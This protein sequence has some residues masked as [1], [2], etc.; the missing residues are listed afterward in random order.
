MTHQKQIGALKAKGED[1]SQLI[2]EVA[3]IKAQAPAKEAE[4]AELAAQQHTFNV[5]AEYS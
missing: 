2:D 1:A 4:E 3:E 5:F